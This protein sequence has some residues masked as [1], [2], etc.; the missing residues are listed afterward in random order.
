MMTPLTVWVPSDC[1]RAHDILPILPIH[2]KNIRRINQTLAKFN[3]QQ[4]TKKFVIEKEHTAPST[5]SIF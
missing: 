1:R 2:D 4:P 5:F 3:K